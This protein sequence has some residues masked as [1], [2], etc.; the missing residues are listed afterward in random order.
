MSAPPPPKKHRLLPERPGRTHRVEID[1]TKVYVTTGEYEDGTLGEVFIRI[2]KEGGRLRVYDAL[3]IAIS[4]GLQHGVPLR[5]YVDKLRNL[6]MEPRGWTRNPEIPSAKSICD[7]LAR[8][9]E[10]RYLTAD[11]GDA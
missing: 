3:A 2:D 10:A 9:L 1:G 8:F 5:E 4:I 7:Y 6:Q 11:A